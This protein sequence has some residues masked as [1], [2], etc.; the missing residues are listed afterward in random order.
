MLVKLLVIG[1]TLPVIA[2]ERPSIV[3]IY[4]DDQDPT[5]IGIDNVELKTPHMDRL[6]R[7]GARLAN[8][9][10]T[11]P[12]CSTARASLMSSRFGTEL[13]ITDWINPRREADHGLDP[14]IV[15]WLELF[16]E[17]GY[18]N[19]LV[20]KWHLGTADRFHPTRTGFQYFMGFRSGGTTPKNPVLE[21]DGQT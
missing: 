10:V 16:A 1:M 7:E 13:G 18:K 3:F 11:T 14:K 4:S 5:A 20:G 6:L 2:N 15:T 8:S 19:G 12:V 21:I 9:F 17:A